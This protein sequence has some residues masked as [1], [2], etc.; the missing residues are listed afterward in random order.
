MLKRKESEGRNRNTGQIVEGLEGHVKRV[1]FYSV[2]FRKPT[3]RS[4]EQGSDIARCHGEEREGGR[5]TS[6]KDPANLIQICLHLSRGDLQFC[7][8]EDRTAIG[9]WKTK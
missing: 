7:E 3:I 6:W 5:G 9:I 8:F 4:Q 1:W 2:G